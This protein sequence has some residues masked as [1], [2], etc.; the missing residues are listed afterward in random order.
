MVSQATW[1]FQRKDCLTFAAIVLLLI[2]EQACST[3][4]CPNHEHDFREAGWGVTRISI[5]SK[6]RWVT[7]SKTKLIGITVSSNSVQ[8]GAEI[9]H[10]FYIKSAVTMCSKCGM[11]TGMVFMTLDQLRQV[12][13]LRPALEPLLQ[14]AIAAQH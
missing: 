6:V 8:G 7:R 5:H 9:T 3:K 13:A 11:A 1:F 14:K 10:E 2:L 4:A 12:A